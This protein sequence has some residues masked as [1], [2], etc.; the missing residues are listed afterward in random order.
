[1][2]AALD[3]LLAG[4]E[5]S[6]NRPLPPAREEL[7]SQ[8]QSF[9]PRPSN[10]PLDVVLTHY[11]HANLAEVMEFWQLVLKAIPLQPYVFI[12]CKSNS[13]L[14]D[15]GW[16]QDFGELHTLENVGRESHS[17][18]WHILQHR[19][20]LADHT[21]F[22]QAMPD[23]DSALMTTR[24]KQFDA[25]TGMLGLAMI[26][27]CGCAD[28]YLGEVPFIKEIWAMMQYDFCSP[29]L[30][31]STFMKGAFLVS[32]RRLLAVPEKVY[33]SLFA[34]LAAPNGHWVHQQHTF[35]GWKNVNSPLAG[36][37]ME[38][39]WNILFDCLDVIHTQHCW[40]C[41][42][43]KQCPSTGCQC[44]DAPHLEAVTS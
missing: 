40:Q 30:K 2:L 29:E 21:L 31:Y 18:L 26:V 9:R 43:G 42:E 36:H 19:H 41:D 13:S 12:Y 15:F 6:G 7:R 34:L 37:I 27:E 24:L 11:H 25:T 35:E 32:K 39:A 20:D 4:A 10:R 33:R 17:Y 22:N 14:E 23:M 3:A 44:R 5:G 28:C 8:L 16:M 1:M 38:R